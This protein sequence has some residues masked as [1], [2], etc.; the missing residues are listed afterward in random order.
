MPI[1]TRRSA[2]PHGHAL[3]LTA[4]DMVTGMIAPGVRLPPPAVKSLAG[5]LCKNRG[6]DGSLCSG[7]H[8]RHARP[9][10]L[11]LRARPG[12]PSAAVP[13]LAGGAVLEVLL[14]G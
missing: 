10:G 13:L 6:R 3:P 7:D 8:G 9:R 11:G 4:L 1:P 5:G 12:Q 14:L 2:R